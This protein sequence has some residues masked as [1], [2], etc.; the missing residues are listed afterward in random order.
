MMPEVLDP[1][2]LPET[3]PD[4]F[5]P[6]RNLLSDLGY[7]GPP[8]EPEAPDDQSGVQQRNIVDRGLDAKDQFDQGNELLGKGKEKLAAKKAGKEGLKEGVEKQGAAASRRKVATQ[9]AQQVAKA[10]AKTAATTAVKAGATAATL[11]TEAATG[12]VGW[13]AGAITILSLIGK[14][15]WNGVKKS[16][17]YI[18]IAVAV[19]LLL[20]AVP[21]GL[22]GG[23]GADIKPTTA[24]E[25][26]Q[27]V[28]AAA[29]AGNLIA[30]RQVTQ[31]NVDDIKARY[32][33][34]V[35]LA[36]PEKRAEVEKLT[37]EI[38]GL[39]DQL[40]S[41][42]G[43]PQKALLT[44]IKAKEKA[45]IDKYGELFAETGT[46][47][48]L[49]PFI[50]SGQFRVGSGP[51]AKNI[52]LGKM[53]IKASGKIEP[54]SQGLCKMLVLALKS[55]YK[56]HTDTLSYG[57]PILTKKG[58][59]SDHTCGAAIDINYVNADA[60][61]TFDRKHHADNGNP[62]IG[63][64][65]KLW[66]DAGLAGTIYVK[67]MIVPSAFKEFGMKGNQ[68]KTDYSRAL[69]ADHEDHIHLAGQ[70]EP[71]ACQ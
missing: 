55:G 6:N 57:H 15:L 32:K 19:L 42:S 5:D 20:L 31:K 10:G 52:I 63:K 68:Q 22:L 23:K 70:L 1:E 13:V 45:L 33:Q 41:L 51:N 66:Y 47:A 26:N 56:I 7:G 36:K 3:S 67:Q 25:K 14:P 35:N 37:N 71:G 34:L 4:G 60:S 65:A 43:E 69:Q 28:V 29:L 44:Q 49:A 11:G 16:G 38:A 64:L 59:R 9:G 53:A 58:N 54:A 62:D 2:Q 50:A 18:I 8:A 61:G 17:K 48:D 24:A 30:G 46:C 27:A 12:P 21:F 40:V 39:L